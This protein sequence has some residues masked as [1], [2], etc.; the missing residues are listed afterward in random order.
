MHKSVEM[1][2]KDIAKGCIKNKISLT[3]SNLSHI[4]A[5]G[6]A[7]S[8]Y[9]DGKELV[10]ATNKK[11]ELDWVDILLHESCHM[12]QFLQKSKFWMPD[13]DALH[14]VHDWVAK[15]E[16]SPQKLVM[17]FSNTISMELDCE[18]RT[19]R[20]I[21]KYKIPVDIGVYSQKANSYLFG[22]GYTHQTKKWYKSPYENPKI[23]KKMPEKLLTVKTYL[24]CKDYLDLYKD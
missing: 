16:V 6:L 14:I 20:K 13:E 24:E 22:Y 9:F 7:C 11:K 17:G 12:D 18:K 4:D 2:L 15:K 10:V 3:L 5:D 19:V 21:L 1:F 8:G 23:W